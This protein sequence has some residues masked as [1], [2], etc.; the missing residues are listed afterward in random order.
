MGPQPEAGLRGACLLGQW[1]ALGVPG[2][3]GEWP[4]HAWSC[5]NTAPRGSSPARLGQ[6]FG[7]PGVGAGSSRNTPAVAAAPFLEEARLPGQGR[8]LG[9][10][11]GGAASSRNTP[12]VAAIRQPRVPSKDDA[13]MEE[14]LRRASPPV[15]TLRPSFGPLRP[16]GAPWPPASLRPPPPLWPL[17]HLLHLPEGRLQECWP[18]GPIAF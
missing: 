15:G 16:P 8:L 5:R 12:G 4:Q 7:R 9:A 10:F 14:S 11:R 6:C 17:R 18:I 3:R 2:W 1:C 13:E